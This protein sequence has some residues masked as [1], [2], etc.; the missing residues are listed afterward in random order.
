MRKKISLSISSVILTLVVMELILRLLNLPIELNKDFQ[1]KDL[2]WTE[3]N[4]VLNSQGYRDKEYPLERS[5]NSFR[6]YTVGDSYTYGWL[7][8]NQQEVF[9]KFVENELNKK[10][11]KKVEVINAGSPGFS[12]NEDVNRFI[13]EGK[14]YYPDLVVV[15]IN[16]DEANYTKTFVQPLDLKWNKFI[17]SLHLYQ[18]TLG[19]FFKKKAEDINHDYVIKIYTDNNSKDWEK[20]AEQVLLLKQEANKINAQLAI[21]LFPHI[22]PSKPNV[23][24]DFYSFNQKFKQFGGKNGIFII[25]P[26]ADFLKYPDKEKLV[27]NPLDPHPTA[28][29]NKIVANAFLK[30]FNFEEYIKNHTPYIPISQ[31][32]QVSESNL[33]IGPYELIKNIAGNLSLPWVYFETKNGASI[34]NFPLRDKASR[35]TNFYVD[36]LQ[37]AK[38]FTHTGIAG[39]TIEYHLYPTE[40]GIIKIPKTIY[41]YNVVGINHIFALKIADDG[42]VSSDYLSPNSIKKN[43]S[44]FIINYDRREDYHNFRVNLTVATKQLDIDPEGNIVNIIKTEVLTKK[45]DSDSQSVVL[46]ITEKISSWQVFSNEPGKNETIAYVDG[47]M[48]RVSEIKTDQNGITLNFFRKLHKGQEVSFAVARNYNLNDETINIEF[49]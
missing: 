1:R 48:T 3:K 18:I 24:Y 37:T 38:S 40:S 12:I 30:Q 26:L 34:Q 11:D 46:S 10:L 25:D 6:V 39:A 44:E 23:P 35:M 31:N 8:D 21:V 36:D 19:N 42:N 41:G 29:M 14:Y 28:E 33:K 2:Y 43:D 15:G 4:V 16:D 22:L 47:D 32:I 7:V 45:L 49:E 9:T 13:S 5:E 17:R 20:F 27:V